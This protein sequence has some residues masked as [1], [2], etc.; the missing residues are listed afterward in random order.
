MATY[1][2]QSQPD[3]ALYEL[4]ARGK[5][6]TYFIT[7]NP[8]EGGYPFINQ[9]NKIEPHLT[10]RRI[11]VSRN[12]P[13][14]KQ[15]IEFE[16]D[17][18]GDLLTGLRFIISMPT[19]LPQ[20]QLQQGSLPVDPQIV[21]KCL[22]LHAEDGYCY[23]WMRHAAYFLID[24]LELFQDK[25]LI[26]QTTGDA[27]WLSQ[28]TE[29]SNSSAD[30]RASQTGQHQGAP[31]QVAMNATL[32]KLY[33]DIPFINF[34]PLATNPFPLISV[35]A[36]TYRIKLKLKSAEHLIEAVAAPNTTPRTQP[37]APWGKQF[38][39]EDIN[40][41]PIS[42]TALTEEAMKPPTILLESHQAYLRE[43]ARALL[44]SSSFK[45]ESTFRRWYI[46]RFPINEM[47]YNPFNTNGQ[48]IITRRLEGCHPTERLLFAVRARRDIDCGRP[49]K[50]MGS[51]TA[52]NP[53]GMYWS[54][55]K[56]LIAGR[57]REFAWP[58]LVYEELAGLKTQR[59]LP[60]G[61]G[62]INFSIE[63]DNGGT[64]NM[65]QADRP[66][67]QIQLLDAG[68]RQTELMVVSEAIGVYCIEGGKAYV[69]FIN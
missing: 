19:W 59:T 50:L 21:N 4:V 12:A 64:I 69:K 25:T 13:Q 2:P 35:T 23:G 10:E 40:G 48:V 67:I 5:K 15:T 3:G 8:A 14:F 41:A 38:H 30:L 51:A 45:W 56:F 26:Y 42:V 66:S 65:S 6:D 16:I 36:H 46:N 18:Y 62:S 55:V 61:M 27:L 39:Y 11:H 43:E 54:S 60:A 37:T 29:G 17:K 58:A 34:A 44:R 1:I 32:D 33:L 49:W 7:S 53:T 63:G 57:E 9:Y 22:L 20:L 28:T 31:H 47:E 24:T 68:E 52:A